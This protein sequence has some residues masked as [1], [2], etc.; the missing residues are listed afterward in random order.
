[1][2]TSDGGRIDEILGALHELDGVLG[3]MDRLSGL[4]DAA[5]VANRIAHVV[6]QTLGVQLASVAVREGIDHLHMRGTSGTRSEEFGRTHVP[7][8][9]GMGGKILLINRPISIVDYEH[10]TQISNHFVDLVVGLEGIHGISAVPLE[11]QSQLVGVLYAGTRTVGHIGDRALSLMTGLA[12]HFGPHLGAAA[13]ATTRRRLTVEAERQRLGQEL[14]DSVGQLLFGIGATAKKLHDKLPADADDLL[15]ELK[16]IQA[17]TSEAAA[18][19]RDALRALKPAV[20]GDG[21]SVI[22][23]IDADAFA[24]RSGVPIECIVLGEPVHLSAETE[25]ALLS[26][27]REGLL[28]VEKHANASSVILTLCYD[29]RQIQLVLQDDGQ[30]FEEELVLEGTPNG[31]RWGLTSLHGRIERLGGNLDLF[32]NEDGGVTLRASLPTRRVLD[33]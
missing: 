13:A 25:A 4:A 31:D 29:A 24:A 20:P 8:G 6:R 33:V 10:D 30:G 11:Y 7:L 16:T 27:V 23:Q 5:V 9:W 2:A 28:N 17:Q 19:L 32:T 3:A 1:M 21:L 14:H 15:S 26:V 18:Y 22:V 12:H